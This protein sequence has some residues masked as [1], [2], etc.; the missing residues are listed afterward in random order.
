MP[1]TK[2]MLLEKLEI[3]QRKLED[4]FESGNDPHSIRQEIS[5]IQGEIAKLNESLESKGNLLKG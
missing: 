1:A 4:E 5:R 2:E 3:L